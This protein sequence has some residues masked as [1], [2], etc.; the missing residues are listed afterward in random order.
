MFI[1]L[2]H[3][4]FDLLVP[5]GIDRGCEAT[6]MLIRFTPALLY[7]SYLM[8]LHRIF[9]CF[10]LLSPLCSLIASL[11]RPHKQSW[12]ASFKPW[13]RCEIAYKRLAN[14]IPQPAGEVRRYGP[15]IRIIV[16][17]NGVMPS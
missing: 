1:L 15:V 16:E 5:A 13:C 14:V 4:W 3:I 2:R 10:R 12:P 17:A 6:A 8:E 9:L 7:F 11:P